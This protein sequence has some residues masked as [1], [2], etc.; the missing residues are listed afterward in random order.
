MHDDPEKTVRIDAPNPAS[1]WWAVGDA[2]VRGGS[3]AHPLIDGRAAMLAMC[4]AFLTAKRFILLAA[5]DIRADL[6]MVRGEDVRLGD[7]MHPKQRALLAG[8]RAEGL[9]DA[10]ITF[11]DTHPLRVADVLGFAV[12]RGA[13]VGVLLWDAYHLNSHLTNDP[14]HEQAA[15]AA[16]GV[17]C[18]LDDSSRRITH[19]S[20]SLHQKCAVVDGRVAFV[21]GIDLTAQAQGD[22]DRWDTHSHFCFSPERHLDK[23]AA[24]HPWHDVHTRIEGPAVVDVLKNIVERWSEVAARHHAPE[25]PA[26][27]PLVPP[28]PLSDGS[29]VQIVRTIPPSTYTFAPSGIATIKQAYLRA[30]NQAQRFIYLE[31][32]YLWPEIFVGLDRLRWGE[33]S[34]DSMEI[35]EAMGS[36]LERGVH[37]ALVLPDHPNCGRRF[38]DGGVAW[39]R[40]RAP[41]ATGLLT[42]LTLGNSE[43]DAVAPGGV[44]YRPVYVHAKVA[45]VDDLWWTAGSANLNSRGL[46]SDAEINVASSNPTI[47]RDLRMG[48]WAE[49]LRVA[50]EQPP[51]LDDPIAGMVLLRAS[52]QA[53]LERVRRRA[54]LDGH[55]LP[56]LTAAE[57]QATGIPIDPEHGWLDHLPG[58]AGGT[59]SAYAQRY[60]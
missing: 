33:R 56:Y 54:Q 41:G 8:L 48:L 28:A 4:R 38:T 36:A 30:L 13:R 59:S 58:G 9:D 37:L 39:L 55:L 11:W 31:N 27:L 22:Y 52:A 21:G 44:L 35:L 20:Q 15:L 50:Q 40:A 57:A 1:S 16:H 18:L 2:P 49:H 45:V 47:A 42:I 26:S 24:A 5:W 23:S 60:L 10:A 29:P 34:S 12:T 6:L 32:Q 14:R 43:E 53:N 17:D 19:M 46:H 7:D 3:G 51:G 25:W